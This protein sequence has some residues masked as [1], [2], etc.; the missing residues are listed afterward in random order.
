M[1]RLRGLVAAAAVVLVAGV[2]APAGA[3][4]ASPGESFK[5]TGSMASG[6][7]SAEEEVELGL[8]RVLYVGGGDATQV[9]QVKGSK[10]VSEPY[11]QVVAFATTLEDPVTGDPYPA[12]V[13]AIGEGEFVIDGDLTEASLELAADGMVVAFDPDTG[14]EMPTGETIPL[15]ASAHWTG[16]GPLTTSHSHS[17]YTEE[18]LISIDRDKST[19]RPAEVTLTLTNSDT[20]AVLFN[21]MMNE[22]DM[23]VVKAAS[24]IHYR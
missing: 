4:P 1:R 22:G 23:S 5:I 2:A 13:W 9:Y 18:G 6:F 10:P 17:K 12:E 3:A 20:G 7:W 11:A 21:G 14:E 15:V 19:Y 24:L 16:S 8:P